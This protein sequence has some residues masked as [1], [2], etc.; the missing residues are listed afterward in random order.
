MS[1]R[2][3]RTDIEVK[4][5]TSD[6]LVIN[7]LLK[8]SQFHSDGNQ[9]G[10]CEMLLDLLDSTPSGRIGAI[11]K[12]NSLFKHWPRF[13]GCFTFPVPHPELDSETAYM[14]TDFCFESNEYGDARRELALF[15]ATNWGES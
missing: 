13:S 1:Y 7:F 9:I 14:T 4:G 15:L 3:P 8:L 2:C 10:M 11:R 12:M 6:E 5:S